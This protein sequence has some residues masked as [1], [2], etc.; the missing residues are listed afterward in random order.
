MNTFVPGCQDSITKCRKIAARY[1][2][3]KVDSAK[4]YDTDTDPLVFA[5]GHCHIDTCWLW[6]F[7]ETKRTDESSIIILAL[8]WW[9]RQVR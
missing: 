3:D 7:D 9:G 2:G 4:V 5:T 6:P 1:I 8:T